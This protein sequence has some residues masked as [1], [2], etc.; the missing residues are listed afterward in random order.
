MYAHCTYLLEF[1]GIG[2][3]YEFYHNKSLKELLC[4]KGGILCSNVSVRFFIGYIKII[5]FLQKRKY[6]N[7][8][9]PLMDGNI[10]LKYYLNH[11]IP[12]YF[13]RPNYSFMQMFIIIEQM[14]TWP[15]FAALSS[16]DQVFQ[17]EKFKILFGIKLYLLFWSLKC[18]TFY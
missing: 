7:H 3:F 6:G 12:L 17:F 13:A 11:P 14:Q 5:S 15:L 10:R 8:S 1:G 16:Q 2:L 18:V 4:S 9:Q